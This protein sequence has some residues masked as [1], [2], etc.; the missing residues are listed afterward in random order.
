MRE[1]AAARAAAE[2]VVAVVAVGAAEDE[3][4]AEGA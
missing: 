1:G 2:A 4:V 3:A